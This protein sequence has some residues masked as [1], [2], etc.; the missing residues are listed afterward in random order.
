[1]GRIRGGTGPNKTNKDAFSIQRVLGVE[2][3][4]SI[5][6]L[7]DLGREDW[8]TL[9][10]GP[11]QAPLVGLGIVETE[12]QTFDMA[13]SR[14]IGFELLQLSPA[15]PNLTGYGSTVKFDPDGRARQWI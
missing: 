4:L 12:G 8:A 14:A 3:T 9:S 15:I 7:A 13:G 1:M 5:F 2:L 11:V 10:V 6:K